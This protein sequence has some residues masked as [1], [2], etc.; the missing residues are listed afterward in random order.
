[1][2]KRRLQTYEAIYQAL[3]VPKY[4]EQVKA[5]RSSLQV[6]Q[7]V[8]AMYIN[9]STSTVPAWE[10]GKKILAALHANF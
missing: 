4:T 5:L 3:Q 7:S 2:N 10:A 1:M 9:T 8:F 6:S